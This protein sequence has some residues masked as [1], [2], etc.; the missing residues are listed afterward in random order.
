M[1]NN[2]TLRFWSKSAHPYT[3]TNSKK[4]GHSYKSISCSAAHESL[5]IL[6][7]LKFSDSV[8]KNGYWRLI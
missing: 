8:I 6:Q 1:L 2:R 5:I 4:H 7:T 3:T